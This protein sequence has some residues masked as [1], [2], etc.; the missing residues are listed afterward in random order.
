M[1]KGPTSNNIKMITSFCCLVFYK[2]SRG[3][4]YVLLISV[5]ILR[6]ICV[7]TLYFVVDGLEKLS[8]AAQ[9]IKKNI[10]RTKEGILDVLLIVM[11]PE[12]IR[13]YGRNI[14]NIKRYP[15]KIMVYGQW[16]IAWHCSSI[17]NQR[18]LSI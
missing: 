3:T 10:W 12:D 2:I 8:L 5:K 11:M 4:H 13:V 6:D 1:Q 17:P 7:S 15:S 16:P 9:F 18:R 14:R